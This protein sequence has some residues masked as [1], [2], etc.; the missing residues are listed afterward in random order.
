MVRVI[1]KAEQDRV[2]YWFHSPQSSVS[3]ISQ[4][5]GS[6]GICKWSFCSH[7]FPRS[8]VKTVWISSRLS[9]KAQDE[10]GMIG[11]LEICKRN[12]PNSS[13]PPNLVLN[14]ITFPFAV[15]VFFACDLGTHVLL[16]HWLRAKISDRIVRL[17][18]S[19]NVS[20]M[21]PTLR[22][23]TSNSKD[24]VCWDLQIPVPF[25]LWSFAHAYALQLNY[26]SLQCNVRGG[27]PVK[28]L[29]NCICVDP[30]RDC[31]TRLDHFDTSSLI[32][33]VDWMF[34]NFDKKFW[35]RSQW[36]EMNC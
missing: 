35:L 32:H 6:G 29:E 2:Y 1:L 15:F 18:R 21:T 22:F 16:S 26:L 5:G 31:Y 4:G 33:S 7:L 34:V 28:L 8:V 27:H 19:G 17:K 20:E 3:F 9:W 23:L 24:F 30:I 12:F 11:K 10:Y 14:L 13:P 36:S 25:L